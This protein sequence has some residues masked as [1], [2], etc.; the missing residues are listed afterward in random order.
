MARDAVL[1][2]RQHRDT[3]QGVQEPGCRPGP[4]RE[5]RR[6]RTGTPASQGSRLRS[7]FTSLGTGWRTTASSQS[8]RPTPGLRIGAINPNVFQEDEYRLGSVCNP[9][10][11]IRR[12]ATDHLLECVEIAEATGSPAISLWFADGT[13]Y[14]GQDDIRARQDRPRRGVEHRLR[15]DARR[16]RDAPRVQ[17]VRAGLLHDGRAGLGYVAR[18]LPGS[19]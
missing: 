9:D 5:D 8:T 1:G 3:I 14:P 16:H 6:C 12:K 10:A 7:R 15:G 4:L 2:V 19:G 13:N 18:A 17:V 11:E